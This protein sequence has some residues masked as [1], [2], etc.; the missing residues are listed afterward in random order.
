MSRSPRTAGFSLVELLITVVIMGIITAAT[1]SLF[2]SQN[3]AF[4]MGTERF[5]MLQ[6]TRNSMELTE[7]VIRTMGAGVTGHQPVLV[8][9]SDNLLAF[10]TDYI[11]RD[12]VDMRWAS[13]FNPDAE[14]GTDTAW[15]EEEAA[16]LPGTAYTYPST[17]Y[18]MS[19]GAV[20]PAETYLLYFELD[21]TTDRADDYALYQRVNNG[22]AEVLARNILPAQ[23]GAPFFQYLLHRVTGTGDTLLYASG[24]ILPLI[25]RE[26]VEGISAS[27]SMAYVRPDS[28]R[29]IRIS[30]RVTNGKTGAEERARDVTTLIETPNNGIPM[31]TVCGRPPFAPLAFAAADAGDG[32]GKVTFTW[33]ASEDQDTGE[34]DI[35]QYILWRRLAT[36]AAFGAPLLV[37]RAETGTSTYTAEILDHVPGEMYT[38]GIAAQDCTP[39]LSSIPTATVTI[40]TPP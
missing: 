18:R 6:G 38:F 14:E 25:R 21:G 15:P 39:N 20:S 17:T 24:P 27:D 37:I 34:V 30:Y 36:E 1:V 8:Y 4:R 28:V 26:L 22:V 33:T 2:R 16:V 7:R 35:R 31:P 11:E 13:Y 23:S 5:D 9:G 29:A 3:M 40:A 12:T 32:S 10:N 19:N